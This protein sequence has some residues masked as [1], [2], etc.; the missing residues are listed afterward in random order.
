MMLFY[1][2]IVD[3]TINLMQSCNVK[4]YLALVS[5]E[6]YK[7]YKACHTHCD[8][9]HL[10]KLSSPRTRDTHSPARL[11]AEELS[12]P[13]FM[14][15]VSR[16]RIQPSVCEENAQQI[17]PASRPIDINTAIRWLE[18]SL[19]GVVYCLPKSL[20]TMSRG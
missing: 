11:L 15:K 3:F 6:Q 9:G 7:I 8:K 19:E 10:F 12:L 16:E 18:R 2:L 4:I 1:A 5:I 13:I 20:F 17:V 14:T